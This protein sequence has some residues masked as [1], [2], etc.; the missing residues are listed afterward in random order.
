MITPTQQ[1]DWIKTRSFDFPFVR[2]LADF[3]REFHLS[4]DPVKQVKELSR[5]APFQWI[6]AA[7][8]D[9]REAILSAAGTVVKGDFVGHPFRGNQWSNASGGG[10]GDT[11][12]SPAPDEQAYNMRQQGKSWEAIAKELGYANGGSVRRLA[13]RHE[14]LLQDK[15]VVPVVKPVVPKPDAVEDSAVDD[16]K[17]ADS[18]SIKRARRLLNETFKG[19]VVTTLANALDAANGFGNQ[20][21]SAAEAQIIANVTE[22]G[23]LMQAAFEAEMAKLSGRDPV[24]TAQSAKEL[25]AILERQNTDG[26]VGRKLVFDA[27]HLIGRNFQATV[28]DLAS[29]GEQLVKANGVKETDPNSFRQS[30]VYVNNQRFVPNG[31]RDIDNDAMV[32]ADQAVKY[33]ARLIRD[34]ING[35]MTRDQLAT[36][37]T[38]TNILAGAV[39]DSNQTD[40][41]LSVLGGWEGKDKESSWNPDRNYQVLSVESRKEMFVY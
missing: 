5:F 39:L 10:R 26:Q 36:A 1:E 31:R 14:K 27:T 11:G 12:S 22:A 19:D 40:A 16:R 25:D 8:A 4:A 2:N 20:P 13:M 21:A 28:D 29:L 32:V 34:V 41:G 37:L 18:L 7:P 24:F 35:N 15:G 3:I 23:N 38:S 33:S 30:Y 6:N 17:V 9:V